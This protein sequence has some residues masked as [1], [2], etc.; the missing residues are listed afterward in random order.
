MV[1]SDIGELA[2]EQLDVILG[3]VD[4]MNLEQFIAARCA[5]LMG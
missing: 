3:F 1:R 2:I 5:E 4:L